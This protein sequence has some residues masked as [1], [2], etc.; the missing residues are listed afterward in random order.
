MQWPRPL[1][2]ALNKNGLAIQG[3]RSL[4]SLTPGY[5]L[6]RLRRAAAR[7]LRLGFGHEP[8][9]IVNAKLRLDPVATA[10][11]SDTLQSRTTRGR[12]FLMIVEPDFV[13]AVVS[14]TSSISAPRLA[15]AASF[16][17]GFFTQSFADTNETLS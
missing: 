5:L 12:T 14:I 3:C 7:P 9:L 11:G 8:A 10:R 15:R 2:R 16:S 1:K 13:L 4:R 17:F 6:A